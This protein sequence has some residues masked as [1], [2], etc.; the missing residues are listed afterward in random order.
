MRSCSCPAR[1]SRRA[2]SWS[3]VYLPGT[4]ICPS[5]SDCSRCCTAEPPPTRSRDPDVPIRT[6]A[7]RIEQK[8]RFP[9]R[10]EARRTTRERVRPRDVVAFTLSTTYQK[11]RGGFAYLRSSRWC[12]C[13]R[14]AAEGKLVVPNLRRSHRPTRA[15]RLLDA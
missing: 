7:E 8:G 12:R 10:T 6:N 15:I 2:A 13:R 4:H 1:S 5:F 3:T 9:T 14:R 11:R